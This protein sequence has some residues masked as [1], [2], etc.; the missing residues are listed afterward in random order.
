MD[1]DKEMELGFRLGTSCAPDA[2][3]H[4]CATMVWHFA[5]LFFFGR[6][7]R[8]RQSLLKPKL[9]L[10]Y[11]AEDDPLA[12]TCQVLGSLCASMLGLYGPGKQTQDFLHARQVSNN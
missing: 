2:T 9:A 3:L 7:E 10:N 8:L 11:V 1:V 6:E 12:S 5:F 4:L